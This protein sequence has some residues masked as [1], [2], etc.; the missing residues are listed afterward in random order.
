FARL[1]IGPVM[2]RDEIE[3]YKEM[4]LLEPLTVTYVLAGLSPD[5]SRFRFRNEFF[6]EDGKLVARVTST[7]GWLDLTT[8]KLAAPPASLAEVIRALQK[9]DDYQELPASAKRT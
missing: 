1:Q 9:T 6:R 5:A 3:Y 8:R 7:G 2:M 4:H